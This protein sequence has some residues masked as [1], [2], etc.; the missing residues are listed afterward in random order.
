MKKFIILFAALGLLTACGGPTFKSN[1]VVLADWYQGNW[2][3]GKVTEACKE[4]ANASGGQGWKVT[5]NDVFYNA[6]GSQQ[7]VCYTAD[8]LVLNTAPSA[9]DI[10]SGDT[11]LAEWKEDAYYSAKIQ[12]IDGDKYSVK[13]LVD[14][15]EL[16][17]TL[18][19]LRILPAQK[20]VD[21]KTK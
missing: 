21:P 14:G 7:P 12:K 2:H 10:K 13:F 19:K 5:F 4:G 17:L 1:D 20:T 8:K 16:T 3:I 18:D 11:V 6:T 9:G 15:L